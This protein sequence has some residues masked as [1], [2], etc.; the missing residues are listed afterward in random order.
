MAIVTEDV[1]RLPDEREEYVR[2]ACQGDEVLLREVAEA[3]EWEGRM[4]GFLRQPAASAS[5]NPVREG[6][7]ARPPEGYHSPRPEALGGG[8]IADRR[9]IHSDAKTFWGLAV[10]HEAAQKVVVRGSG[11]GSVGPAPFEFAQFEDVAGPG[12]DQRIVALHSRMVTPENRA[13]GR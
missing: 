11:P 8:T 2:G 4:G 6:G 3:V 10:R 7:T 12:G 5:Q 13:S 9:F 1:R